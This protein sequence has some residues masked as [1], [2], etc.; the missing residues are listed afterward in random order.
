MDN[1]N[2]E[3]SLKLPNIK[4]RITHWREARA[5]KTRVLCTRRLWCAALVTRAVIT[6]ALTSQ[7]IYFLVALDVTSVTEAVKTLRKRLRGADTERPNPLNNPS[8]SRKEACTRSSPGTILSK[9]LY[10]KFVFSLDKTQNL[11]VR[12]FFFSST[13]TRNPFISLRFTPLCI[14]SVRNLFQC[15]NFCFVW[16]IISGQ[17]APLT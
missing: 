8:S 10:Y 17:L 12:H 2:Q 1:E 15:P 9:G 7:S 13:V 6:T 4:T 3:R 14:Q 5:I 16:G 11:T